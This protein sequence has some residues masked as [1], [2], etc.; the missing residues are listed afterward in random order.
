MQLRTAPLLATDRDAAIFV[1]PEGFSELVAYARSGVNVLVA[2]RRGVG[3]TSVLHQL[4]RRLQHDGRNHPVYAELSAADSTTRALETIY[5]AATGQQPAPANESV[6]SRTGESI[7]DLRL[8]EL[9]GL[10]PCAIL[11]DGLAG[12]VAYGLFGTL[13]DRLWDTG[14]Q[15]IFVTSDKGK[16]DFVRPPADA[17]WEQQVTLRYQPGHLIDMLSLRNDGTP[18]PWAADLV[19]A[20]PRIPRE[21]LRAAQRIEAGTETPPQV[22]GRHEE[23]ERRVS[24]LPRAEAMVLAELEG[25]GSASASDPELLQRLGY[26]R[27]SVA[28][29]L[30]GLLAA[31]LVDAREEANGPGRPKIVY[32]PTSGA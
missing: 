5:V 24:N 31:K 10:E 15:F 7:T 27:A 20:M 3:K 12:P 9:G 26:S 8:A 19:D 11:G 22:A 32:T 29:A 30:R 6:L 25:L 2:G 13:R 23:R 18:P 4:E 17:F 1:E 14:H 16:G 28:R 21:V